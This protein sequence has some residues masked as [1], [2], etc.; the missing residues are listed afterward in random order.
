LHTRTFK[1]YPPDNPFF[2]PEIIGSKLFVSR[3][4]I[5]RLL[6]GVWK[7]FWA[8]RPF[9]AGPGETVMVLS[10]PAAPCRNPFRARKAYPAVSDV[11]P[12][13]DP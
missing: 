7:M 6:N 9:R 10:N 4:Q 5:F 1:D 11:S 13:R 12:D 2:S 3:I 8:L